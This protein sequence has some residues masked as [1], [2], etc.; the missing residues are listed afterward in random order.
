MRRV[1]QFRDGI[2]KGSRQC[3]GICLQNFGTAGGKADHGFTRPP[4]RWLANIG[5]QALQTP[6]QPM[7][8]A[9]VAKR[10]HTA[11]G[12]HAGH[13]KANA[14]EDEGGIVTR[15]GPGTFILA[16]I[17]DGDG[18]PRV[19]RVD[20]LAG[21]AQAGQQLVA[22]LVDTGVECRTGNKTVLAADA[23]TA[24]RHHLQRRV[25]PF[26]AAAIRARLDPGMGIGI[27]NG[28]EAAEIIPFAAQISHRDIRLDT[29]GTKRRCHG[30]GE[31]G[32]V[33]AACLEKETVQRIVVRQ[34]QRCVIAVCVCKP[35]H[36]QINESTITCHAGPCLTRPLRETGIDRGERGHFRRRDHARRNADTA[37]LNTARIGQRRGNQLTLQVIAVVGAETGRPVGCRQCCR[38]MIIQ[39]Q[40]IAVFGCLDSKAAGTDGTSLCTAAPGAR[41]FPVEY[42]HPPI[43]RGRVARGCFRHRAK[44][45]C[46]IG[47]KITHTTG[48]NLI[49]QGDALLRCKPRD[50]PGRDARYR[51]EQQN[52]QR[53]NS[54]GNQK[55]RQPAQVQIVETEAGQ[56]RAVPV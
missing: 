8:R 34:A 4:R 28:P 55:H 23:H 16:V 49:R 18:N 26:P 5:Q 40:G 39:K 53:G 13:G 3:R 14:K 44:G 15:T 35:A 42:E 27:A 25:E 11:N 30:C 51:D 33:T 20:P 37:N 38:I 48:R 17:H 56:R 21:S 52:D 24:A 54:G 6:F 36:Q 19:Q 50:E 46:I 2:G 1:S 22:V 12:Q 43:T 31:I 7:L 45:D 32:A 47:Q 29:G 41:G 10:H 9:P